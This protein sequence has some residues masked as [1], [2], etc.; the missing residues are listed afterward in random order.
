MTD[1]KKG[2]PAS[3][4]PPME[5][6]LRAHLGEQLRRIYDMTLSEPIPSR[7]TALIEQLERGAGA[8]KPDAEDDD[9]SEDAQTMQ[10]RS[11]SRF[12]GDAR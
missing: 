11:R 9:R 3:V 4:A 1:D 2:G 6:G 8:D 10:A 7:F 5:A 12:E